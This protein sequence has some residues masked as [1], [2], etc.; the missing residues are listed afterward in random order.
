[1]STFAI[2]SDFGR[3]AVWTM[4]SRLP[5]FIPLLCNAQ[6]LL[7]EIKITTIRQFLRGKT[8]IPGKQRIMKN[9]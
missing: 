6:C 7:P 1:T 2:L 9:N 8:S 4:H 3:P 5:Q